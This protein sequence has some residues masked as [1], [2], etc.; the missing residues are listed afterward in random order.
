MCSRPRSRSGN[1]SPARLS[2]PA[3]RTVSIVQAEFTQRVTEG[4]IVIGTTGNRP[5]YTC[6]LTF[7]KPGSAFLPDYAPALRYRLL[8]RRGYLY[9]TYQPAYFATFQFSAVNL[10]GVKIPRRSA[11]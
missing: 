6:G 5:A 7:L 11:L 9:R 3:H 10:F 8:E 4:F 1:Q 2:F